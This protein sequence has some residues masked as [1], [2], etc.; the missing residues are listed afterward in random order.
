MFSLLNDLHKPPRHSCEY[1]WTFETV[2][3]GETGS[4]SMKNRVASWSVK[5]KQ[6]YLANVRV[7]NGRSENSMIVPVHSS[8]TAAIKVGSVH[9]YRL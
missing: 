9:A 4:L 5:G 8:R 1:K 3:A 6:K 7:L 2:G